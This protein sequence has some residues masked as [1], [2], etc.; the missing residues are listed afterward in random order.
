M[1]NLEEIAQR[2]AQPEISRVEDIDDLK[3]FSDKY[4][5][6]QLFP[7]LYLK[8]L[9]QHN[10]I[11]F[12]EELTKYAYCIS[13][14]SQLYALIH[15]ENAT[16]NTQNL[17][18]TE[19]IVSINEAPIQQIATETIQAI[20]EPVVEE[21]LAPVVEQALEESLPDV[22]NVEEVEAEI[23]TPI[24]VPVEISIDNQ[25]IEP[26]ISP[27]VL[28]EEDE[29]EDFDAEFISLNIR[30]NEELQQEDIEVPI[31]E[32]EPVS[33]VEEQEDPIIEKFEREI[34]SE[35][36]SANYNLDHLAPLEATKIDEEIEEEIFVPTVNS[37]SGKKSFS[38]WLRSNENDE[39]PKFDAEKD[40]INAIV[41]QFIK[42][43]PKISRP[44]KETIIEEKPKK[45]FFSPIKKA[46]ESLD[47]H[48]MPVSE[49]LAKIFALQGNYPKAIFAYE[50]L[51]LINPEKKIFFASRIEELKKKLNT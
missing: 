48:S 29:E 20:E 45:E 19:E 38:S 41:D 2:I 39:Q 30:G 23:E 22:E 51:I 9:A 27:I 35:A 40:R 37:V 1:L 6:C 7:I 25:E 14:R 32:A 49:T 36:I 26:S 18:V 15:T 10:D 12:E 24:E 4:P 43:E 50:Q 28:D 17:S 3:L 42:E 5:Y 47:V 8:A 16:G 21:I 11:R 33:E 44:S 13:D 31:V 34:F 46:K